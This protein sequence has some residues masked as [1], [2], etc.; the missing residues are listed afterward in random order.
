MTEK[1]QKQLDAL[2][3]MARLINYIAPTFRM[4]D[5]YDEPP[6]WRKHWF[7]DPMCS[8]GKICVSTVLAADD[9]SERIRNELCQEVKTP[10]L[11]I[12]SGKDDVCCSQEAK[13][14]YELCP[15]TDKQL[16][17]INDACH[18][19][20]QDREYASMTIRETISWQNMHLL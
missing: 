9:A 16:I 1:N 20:I 3:P 6:S 14:F 19:I 12:T 8:V 2:K 17:E 11:M 7:D 4:N 15:Y 18:L 5:K 13:K 10:F